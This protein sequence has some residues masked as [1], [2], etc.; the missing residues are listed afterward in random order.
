MVQF[1]TL[2]NKVEEYVPRDDDQDYVVQKVVQEIKHSEDCT[3]PEI[4]L[5]Y[6]VIEAKGP[7]E[8]YDNSKKILIAGCMCGAT[9]SIDV[10]NG[11]MATAKEQYVKDTVSQQAKY[12]SNDSMAKG[13][14]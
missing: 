11:Y 1:I 2:E 3:N 7:T 13:Y 8:T 6:D 9:A 12:S 14:Y 5:S 4:K 10:S